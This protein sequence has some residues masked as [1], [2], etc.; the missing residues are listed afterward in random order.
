MVN[1]IYFIC[2]F[3]SIA[4]F[5]N[6]SIFLIAKIILIDK[7][8]LVNLFQ[9]SYLSHDNEFY[10]R[11]SVNSYC[12]YSFNS[13]INIFWYTLIRIFQIS[14]CFF[15]SI[16]LRKI[17]TLCRVH[18]IIGFLVNL[19]TLMYCTDIMFIIIYD[20]LGMYYYCIFFN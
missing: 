6:S 13:L 20:Y 12:L 14:Q 19:L 2:I 9:F 16:V 17:W 11:N 15:I 1:S 3:Y 8:F 5:L 10:I 18:P 7:R 4:Y